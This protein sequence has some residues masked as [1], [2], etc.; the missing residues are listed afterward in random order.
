MRTLKRLIIVL[1]AGGLLVGGWVTYQL[2]TPVQLPLVPYEFSIKQG[3]S[4]TSVANQLA[5]AGVLDDARLFILLSRIKGL[6]SSVKA[7]DYE[8]AEPITPLELLNRI[9]KGDI[10]QSEIKFIEGW[11]FSR[12]R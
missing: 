5:D 10:S 8:F 7:G 12:H 3:S 2:S 6:A 9:T 11:T 4:L 1:L